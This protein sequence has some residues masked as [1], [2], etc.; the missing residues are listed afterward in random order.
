[1]LIGMFLEQLCIMWC[2]CS[3]STNLNHERMPP[4]DNYY[5]SK[6]ITNIGSNKGITNC[7]N[8]KDNTN[9]CKVLY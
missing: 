6:D 5:N 2:S 9:F 4:N 7:D 3:C 1:M 8:M